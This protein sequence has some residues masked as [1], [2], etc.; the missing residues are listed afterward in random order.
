MSRNDYTSAIAIANIFLEEGKVTIISSKITTE[1]YKKNKFIWNVE[2][3]ALCCILSEHINMRTE[4]K[5]LVD[6]IISY[7]IDQCHR[8]RPA[9]I[10]MTRRT[11]LL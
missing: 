2:L 11:V 6:V 3:V 5:K 7:G 9:V 10:I 8:Y 4:I 1:L